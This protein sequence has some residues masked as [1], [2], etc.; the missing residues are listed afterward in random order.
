MAES[1]GPQHTGLAEVLGLPGVPSA[2]EYSDV[3]LFQLYPY[4]SVHL[5]PEGMMGGEARDRIAGF[6][7]AVGLTPPPEPDHLAALVGLYAALAEREAESDVDAE[8]ALLATARAA[9]LDEHLAPWIFL[10]LERV[11]ELAGPRY[12]AWARVLSDVLRGEVVETGA[13]DGALSS[14]LRAAPPVP[15]PRQDGS[16]AFLKG[17]LAPVRAGAI[18]TRADLA[19]V[20]GDLDIGLRAGERRYALEHLLAQGAE[21][22]LKALACVCRRQAAF[23]LAWADGLEADG[24]TAGASA[25][26]M[27]GRAEGTADLLETLAEES[28]SDSLDFVA[29]V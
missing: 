24:L 17:L 1:P 22:V 4:A 8:R 29:A 20:A 7:R 23:Q 19:A 13:R 21:G 26:F 12:S 2:S 9:L 3:F 5:G 16:E 27:A 28:L 15:D 6:W 10:F 25:R 14:H 18:I 11:R